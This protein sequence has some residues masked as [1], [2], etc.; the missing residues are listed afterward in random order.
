ME[1]VFWEWLSFLVRW[2]HVIAGIAWIGSSFYFVHLDLSLKPREGLPKGAQGEAWQ[3]HGGGFYHMAKYLVAPPALPEKVTWFKWEAY[4]T[5]LTG[6]SLLV[7]VYYADSTLY[8][9]DRSVLDLTEG[10]AIGISLAG[11]A[12]GWLVYDQLCKSS[13]MKSDLSLAVAGFLFL[14]VLSFAFTRVFSGRG[15]FMQMGALIGTMMVANVFFVIIP[16]QHKTV[17]ALKAGRQPDPALGAAGKRRSL[18]NNYLTLPA[19][20][21]MIAGHNPLAFATRWN[22][23]ILALLLVMG[24]SI[25]HFFNTQHKGLPEPW[26]TWGITGVCGLLM[27]WLSSF[28]PVP[29]LATKLTEVRGP[30]DEPARIAFARAEE[31][32]HTR[33]A[34]CHAAEPVWEGIYVA[35]KGVRLEASDDIR[36]QRT[37]IEIA[38]V[39]TRFMPPNNVSEM[40]EAE[41]AIL[42]QWVRSR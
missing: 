14:C 26:W 20:F 11:L 24:V 9:I 8:L 2:T 10:Q 35:P 21:I 25:R 18:H 17:D 4:T 29:S 5:W 41:R 15:A 3:V 31:V 33:C 42:A 7:L 28:G 37:N 27:V 23:L 36:M 40:T 13:H 12:F 6:F 1:V 32:I 22:W 38:A 16:N 39:R 30:A 34:M 19:V